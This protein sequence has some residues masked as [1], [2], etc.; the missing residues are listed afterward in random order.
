MNSEQ[1]EA[2][3]KLFRAQWNIPQAAKALEITEDECKLR[4]K[5]FCKVQP[6]VYPKNL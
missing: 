2:I 4:F 6:A 1:P 5:E 3:W